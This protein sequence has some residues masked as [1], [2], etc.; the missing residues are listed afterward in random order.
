MCKQQVQQNGEWSSWLN[1]NTSLKALNS[2][3]DESV[4]SSSGGMTDLIS[5]MVMDRQNSQSD[6]E[7]RHKKE[8]WKRKK[9][10]D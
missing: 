6:C 10:K 3:G 9:G 4:L 5:A 8:E 2:G 7:P 1:I